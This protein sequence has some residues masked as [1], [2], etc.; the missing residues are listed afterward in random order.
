MIC[1]AI[2]LCIHKLQFDVPP[3]KARGMGDQTNRGTDIRTDKRP[4]VTRTTTVSRLILFHL[5]YLLRM[6]SDSPPPSVDQSLLDCFFVLLFNIFNL[7]GG[8][9]YI[10]SVAQSCIKIVK[11][12]LRTI[13]SYKTRQPSKGSIIF[14][15]DPRMLFST[16][17]AFVWQSIRPLVCLVTLPLYP[18][19]LQACWN[20]DRHYSHT[21]VKN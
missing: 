15:G 13:I 14:S 9:G 6:A 18:P 19:T 12:R 17:R 1:A 4:D 5:Q 8:I 2:S 7:L 10:F 11:L 20:M 3:E 16:E 21:Q